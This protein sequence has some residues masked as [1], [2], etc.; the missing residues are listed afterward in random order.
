[1]QK[2]AGRIIQLA[3][4]IRGSLYDRGLFKSWKLPGHTISIGNITTGG[5]GK[6]PVVMHVSR[7]LSERGRNVCVILRGYGRKDEGR[8]V[9][10]SDG[11][12]LLSTFE[13]AGDEAIE[14]ARNL[15]G[16]AVV[17]ADRDRVGAAFEAAEK[18]G[19]DAFVLD[20][21]FQH[22]KA[23]RDLDIVLI[24]CMNPFADAEPKIPGFLREKP[25]ALKRADIIVITRTN[26]C[27]DIECVEAE[28]KASAH[29]VPIFRASNVITGFQNLDDGD[30][31]QNIAASELQKPFGAFCGI[32]NPEGFFAV[33]AGELG[34][35]AF[36][37][38]FPDHRNYGADDIK[39]IGNLAREYNC[40]CVVTTAKDAVKLQDARFDLP[41]FV[42]ESK[43][44]FEDEEGFGET[45]SSFGFGQS[46]KF[47]V[48]SSK[49]KH[50][51]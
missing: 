49:K 34:E 24:D 30:S 46:S 5:T 36:K 26:S 35:P 47:Q 19:C 40:K 15:L 11:E 25:S 38:P 8:R 42:A 20:D 10:V 48:P 18:F 32:G 45:V 51:S 21:A 7:L 31:L 1:M 43:V 2:F 37:L 16:T 12:S 3:S 14:L 28:I 23:K 44:V 13:E 50:E 33:V 6:T 9:F 39:K 4:A 17:V 29:N 41:V 27:V 22:R